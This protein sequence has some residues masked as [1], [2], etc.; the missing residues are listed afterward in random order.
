MAMYLDGIPLHDNGHAAGFTDSTVVMPI[1]IES[2]E[3]IK[4]PSSVYYG[5]R[6][7]GAS[8]PIQS[9]KSGN[10][11]RMNLRYGSWND[12]T[13]TGLLA[14][15]QGKL[16]HVYAFEKFHSDGY[17]ENSK[18]DRSIFSGRW[19]YN[20]TDKFQASLNLRA[21]NAEWDSAGY[22][23]WLLN[24][25]RDA[26]DDGT[27]ENNGGKRERYD[28]RIWANYL[29]SDRSQLTFYLYGSTLDF[30]R[31]QRGGRTVSNVNADTYPNMTEQYNRH[32]Q[33][34][35]GLTYNWMGQLG[36]RDASFTSGV[37]FAKDMDLPRATWSIPWGRGRSRVPG[38]P[39]SSDVTYSLITPAVLAEF[40]YQAFKFL[41]LRLGARYDWI[42][43]EF[44]N[45]LNPTAAEFN[46]DK[47]YEFFSPKI[48]LIFTPTDRL[49]IYANYG[50]G[51]QV[52]GSLTSGAFYN[53]D[54]NLELTIRDQFEVGARYLPLDW[55]HLEANLFLLR[56][57]KD[58]TYD[59]ETETTT[60]TGDSA[61]K[62][63][64][65]SFNAMPARNFRIRGNY[66]YLDAKYI[67]YRTATVNYNDARL[68][69]APRHVA[70]LE[71]AY[72]HPSGFAGRLTYRLERDNIHALAP[73]RLVNGD[74]N[75]NTYVLKAP[76]ID[77]I[78][79]Q[80]SYKFN[81]NYKLLFDVKNLTDKHYRG[82]AYGWEAATG[83]FLT[84]W[85]NPRAFYLTFQ[86]NWDAKE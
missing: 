39:P 33:I 79:L 67:N 52:P 31:Y 5:M 59:P 50:R 13:A 24:T 78:D 85:R 66:A 11:T 23:S 28:A 21:Y 83:D 35:T 37:T 56:T 74:P 61:R 10:L 69:F 27:G 42:T 71:L 51:F 82:Y 30:T 9:I 43:G 44:K 38:A 48:G 2:A 19:T 72:A 46:Y 62:G 7:V 63:F 18:W 76:D 81:D 26:V 16:S 34:G 36:G 75:P 15:D 4:G 55:L 86:M 14:R 45:N 47:V 1:E 25:D 20:F 41:N 12:I 60:Q 70:N 58:N 57:Q 64:E 22:V 65:L 80:L 54:S 53:P 32:R 40:N 17:R 29:L 6:S 3:I 73:S 49:D 8:I 77:L 84:V 68:T